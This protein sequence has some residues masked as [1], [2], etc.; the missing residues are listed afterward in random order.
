VKQRTEEGD[1]G[2]G[3]RTL[4]HANLLQEGQPEG[5]VHDP[6]LHLRLR[7]APGTIHSSGGGSI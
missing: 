2:L 3:G 5:S 4:I 1:F 7:K 6:I